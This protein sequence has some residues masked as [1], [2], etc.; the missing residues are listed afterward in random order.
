MTDDPYAAHARFYDLEHE[1]YQDDLAMYAGF[2]AEAQRRAA[3]RRGQGARGDANAGGSATAQERHGDPG[4]GPA[5][6]D[7]PG[8]ILELAC[9]SG[10]LLLPLAASGARVTGLDYSPAMLALAREKVR[11]AG[12]QRR[13]K[14]VQ[15]DMRSFDL[16]RAFDLA[17]VGLN[18]LMHLE[19]QHDQ[20]EA[21][22]AAARHLTPDGR[23]VVDLFNP[24]VALPDQQ[25]EG[26][27]FL[28]CLKVLP[29]G[30]HLLHF[31][32][33]RVDR[34]AQLVQMTN[35]YDELQP[36]GQMRR[37]L[38]PFALRY[39]TRSEL[40]AMASVAGLALIAVYGSYDLDHYE[41]DSPRLI[42]VLQRMA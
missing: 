34:A 32:S 31:Q 16:G 40:S 11:A 20:Y 25:Q 22:L 9:G 6:M 15:G 4:A 2:A 41:A 7:E 3:S 18:S 13:V 42:A 33:P 26:A 29:D 19:T 1:D 38:A 39:L 35:Y 27:L 23:L 21:L 12:L 30:S 24:E 10:R 17:I 5:D 37:F 14:L 36:D 8:G 28:H